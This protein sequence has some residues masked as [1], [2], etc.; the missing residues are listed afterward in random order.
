MVVLFRY[1]LTATHLRS[2]IGILQRQREEVA[3]DKVQRIG[4]HQ[5][6]LQQL[7]GVGNLDVAAADGFPIAW[8]W[9]ARP[10]QVAADVRNAVAR[11]ENGKM[12]ESE[13]H[14]N[15][16]IANISPATQHRK[17][18]FM[19]LGLVG[20]I[21]AG[22]SAVARILG[23]LGFVVLDADKDAKAALELPRVREQLIVWWGTD[24]LDADGK[25]DRKRIAAVI[26]ENEAERKRLEALVHPIV[27]SGRA[28]AIEKAQ[29]EGKAGVV[30]DA[31]L[32]FEAGSDKDCDTVL[33]VD[34][35]RE[36]RLRRVVERGW[37]E[38][39]FNRREAAQM[40]LD[41]KKRRSSAVV[42]NDADL[43]TL[44]TRVLGAIDSLSKRN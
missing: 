11:A 29:R 39:E 10:D 37:T 17:T 6:F 42:I 34:S 26:F 33:F 43:A 18:P 4:V 15:S 41:E 30:V 16:P 23:E 28:A 14:V 36:Q 25:V 35:P 13:A 38:A 3:L 27:T 1:E 19:T 20:G 21:G 7:L 12:S 8:Y 9:I 31:P 40:P 24:I 22:K 32:L 5:S 44:Q 2:T